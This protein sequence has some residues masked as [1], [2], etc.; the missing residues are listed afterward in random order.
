MS[1][2]EFKAKWERCREIIKNNLEEHHFRTWFEPLSFYSF[3]TQTNELKINAPSS[4]FNE[5]IGE[6]FAQ[7]TY[8]ALR[9]QFGPEVRLYFRQMTDNENKIAHVV[10]SVN[11]PINSAAQAAKTVS[12]APAPQPSHDVRPELDSHLIAEYSFDNFIEGQSN[13]LPRSVGMSIAKN[14]KMMTFNPLFIYG[15]SG[16]GKTHLVNAIGKAIKELHP[17]KRVLY[18]SAHLFHVQYVDAVRKNTVNDFIRFYQQIDVLIIDDIQEFA[19]L[20]KTQNTF[21]HIFNHL[22]QNGKQLILTCD[23]PPAELQS[24]EERLITRFKWGLLAELGLP[25]EKLRRGILAS[26][27]HRNGLKIPQNVV[28]FISETVTDS[29]RDL[30]GVLNSLMAHS[31]VYNCDIDIEMARRVVGHATKVENK[32]ITI[33]DIIAHTCAACQVS[34]KDLL[35]TSR[36]ANVV[37]ARQIAM[38]LAQKLT[39]LSTSKIGALIG[40][41]NHTTVLHSVTTINDRMST[42]KKLRAK[43]EEIESNIKQHKSLD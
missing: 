38:Y 14:P 34:Q 2:N 31:V 11:V 27:I 39:D 1:Q 6:H 32:P 10:E 22:K 9:N 28:N 8:A 7:L 18:L 12:Q 21:F 36:K 4:F 25:D 5:Y 15:H 30:E 23:R 20:Q 41:R 26:K 33:E 42:D 43:V 19:T 17:D 24:M 13:V 3:N 35:S 16:V 29:V 37:T 40:K